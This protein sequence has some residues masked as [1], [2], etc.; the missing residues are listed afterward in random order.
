[1]YMVEAERHEQFNWK[2]TRH[3]YQE[4]YLSLWNWKQTALGDYTTQKKIRL[5]REN[6]E[7]NR[8]RRDGK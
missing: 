8:Y 4:F 7:K 2:S 3:S 1:M 6:I 5:K